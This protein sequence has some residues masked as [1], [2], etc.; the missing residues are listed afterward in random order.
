M[1]GSTTATG[2]TPFTP[3]EVV[4]I[5]RY[6]GYG[7]PRQG[8]TDTVSAALASLTGDYI[9][10]VR[11]VYLAVLPQLEADVPAMRTKVGTKK[12][13]VWERNEREMEE[14]RFLY[15]EKRLQLCWTLGIE[16]GPFLEVYIPGAF[17]V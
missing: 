3:A 16:S 2:G 5:R 15:R 7:P 8:V 11:S 4:A 10:V 9:D 14:R 17:I 13:A 6:C 1:S 12:A